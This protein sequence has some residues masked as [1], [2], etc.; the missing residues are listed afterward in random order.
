MRVLVIA[1]DEFAQVLTPFEVQGG[2]DVGV[3][4]ISLPLHFV[5]SPLYP[6]RNAI[7]VVFTVTL[8]AIA[9][10]G[11]IIA[12]SIGRPIERLIRAS[13]RV[14]AGDLSVQVETTSSDEVGQLTLTFNA[15][16]N[17]LRQRKYVEDLFGRYVGD[18][19][20]KRILSGEVSLG[21]E[22]IWAT[23]LFADIRGFS[24]HSAKAS[25]LD[26]IDDMNEYYSL[27]QLEVE[28]HNGV[29]NKFG[30]DSILALFGAPLPSPEHARDAV[31]AALA[32]MDQL[33]VLNGHRIA[34]GELPIR[35][36]IGVHTGEMVVGNL[37]S[38][39]RREYTVLGDSVNT[40]KRLSDLN[41]ESPFRTVFISGSTLNELG[42][43]R[44]WQVDDLGTVRVKGKLEQVPVYAIMHR[45]AV[46]SMA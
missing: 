32:M 21:G 43:S 33:A 31:K 22:R 42:I 6:T 16:V 46:G 3:M 13:R 37:G 12:A 39:R 5:T 18:D 2:L 26:L 1:G 28:R 19:I 44:D 40:A 34:R 8:L 25:L 27:M 11:Y 17:Q 38:E 45:T 41:K 4:G 29:I 35:V 36:G 7:A 24:D 14:A 30:G 15:M 23:V 10:I 20:A 9:L